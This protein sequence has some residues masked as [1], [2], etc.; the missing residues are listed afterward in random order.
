MRIVRRVMRIVK[1]AFVR[2][3]GLPGCEQTQLIIGAGREPGEGRG[4]E[5]AFQWVA[6]SARDPAVP[7]GRI[8]D[9]AAKANLASQR[10]TKKRLTQ[11]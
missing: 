8:K 5:S 4:R 1:H 2:R 3:D 6:R 10:L 7:T 9:G 11:Q